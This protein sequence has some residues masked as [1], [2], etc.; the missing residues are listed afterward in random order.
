MQACRILYLLYFMLKLCR[1][2]YGINWIAEK[3][4]MFKI[5]LDEQNA[6]LQ[7]AVYLYFTKRSLLN[8]ATL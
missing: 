3:L 1:F 7:F 6:G 8:Y 2:L 4:F 5:L